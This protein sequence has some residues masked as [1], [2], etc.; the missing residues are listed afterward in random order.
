LPPI[1]DASIFAPCRPNKD[2]ALDFS[3]T[4]IYRKFKI[5]CILDQSFRQDEGGEYYCFLKRLRTGQCTEDDIVRLRTRL[6]KN[7][8]KEEQ[9]EFDDALHIFPT[10]A[11]VREHNM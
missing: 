10:R 11:S 3:I 9:A 6:Q 4:E 7:L 2:T 1:S 8:T 5:V